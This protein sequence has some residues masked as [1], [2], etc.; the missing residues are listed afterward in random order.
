MDCVFI[1]YAYNRCAY[2]F[3]VHK[4]SIED[5]HPNSIMESRNV[6]LVENMFPWKETW[7]YRSFKRTLEA[8][9]SSYHQL[10]DDEVELRKSK[11]ANI[12]KTF[13]PDILTYLLENETWTYSEEISCLKAFY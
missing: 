6:I 12:I 7:E 1:G 2:R 8:S 9:S 5:I 4:S 13:G 3:L 10:E 11:R